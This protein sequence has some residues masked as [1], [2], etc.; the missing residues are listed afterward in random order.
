[1]REIKNRTNELSGNVC[2]GQELYF[3]DKLNQLLTTH[4]S[5]RPHY[6]SSALRIVELPGGSLDQSSKLDRSAQL[7]ERLF[8]L[9]EERAEW[10]F[11]PRSLWPRPGTAPGRSKLSSGEPR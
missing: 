1:M 8:A 2:Q 3:I 10:F 9:G 4:E 5:L 7:I 6:T 11:D